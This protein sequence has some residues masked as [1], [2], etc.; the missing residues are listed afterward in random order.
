MKKIL[1]FIQRNNFISSVLGSA[2]VVIL[3][4]SIDFL[5]LK[6]NLR[7]KEGGK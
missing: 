1:S 2:T 7:I 5:F 4:K 3:F 6:S